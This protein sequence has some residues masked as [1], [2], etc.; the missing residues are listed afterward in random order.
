MFT[1]DKIGIGESI[2]DGNLYIRYSDE[3]ILWNIIDN[4]YQHVTHI[5]Y[6]FRSYEVWTEQEIVKLICVQVNTNLKIK[7][8][9]V[10]WFIIL[11]VNIDLYLKV[12]VGLFLA[13]LEYGINAPVLSN[14]LKLSARNIL[15]PDP[16]LKYA[17]QSRIK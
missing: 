8:I 7:L 12:R 1:V 17:I 16:R 15:V 14:L 5:T 13:T 9:L 3:Y 4:W 2:R 11:H 10:S 6:T